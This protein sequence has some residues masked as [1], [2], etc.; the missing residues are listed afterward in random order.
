MEHIIDKTYEF[1]K[2]FHARDHSGHDFDHIKRVYFNA[3]KIL[4]TEPEADSFIVLMSAL[5]HDIDDHKMGTDGNETQRF[6]S[7]LD[8]DKQTIHKILSTVCAIGFSKS[9]AAPEFETLEQ[10]IV[11]DADKLDAMGTMGILRTIQFSITINR[12]LFNRDIFP[13]ENLTPA[14]YNDMNRAT[15]TAINHFFDKLLK[16][17]NALQTE[18][19]K[20]LGQQRHAFMVDFLRHFFAENN[21]PDWQDYLT[22][23]LQKNTFE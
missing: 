23:Y 3:Q 12:P 7:A 10:K 18:S 22:A 1:A 20:A 9:G 5:L 19:G 4:E 6:L 16:L 8:L 14:V 13:E 2:N 17:K 11:S 21:C 15:N